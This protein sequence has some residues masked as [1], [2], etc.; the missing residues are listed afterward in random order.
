M[1]LAAVNPTELVNKA[2]HTGV[3]EDGSADLGT[4]IQKIIKFVISITI[5]IA[6]IY[7]ILMGIKFITAGG[8]TS[9]AETAQKGITYAIVGIVVA[10]AASV[11]TNFVVQYMTGQ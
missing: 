2:V 11:V 8:D 9:K 10:L 3:N 7:M 5:I 1:L 4:L 6:V